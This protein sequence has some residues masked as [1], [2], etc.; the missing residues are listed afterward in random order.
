[1]KALF[2]PGVRS[3]GALLTL[4][5]LVLLLALPVAVW[6]DLRNLSETSLRRQA[7]DLNSVITGIRGYYASH[8]VG[9]V[10]ASPGSTKVLPNYEE[11]PGAIPIPATLSLELGRVISEQQAN[12][13]YRFVSDFPFRNRT[14]HALDEF[15]TRAMTSLR[16]L[17]NQEPTEVSWSLFTDRVRHVAPIVMG[18]TCVAC[19]NTHPDSPSATGKSATCA[20]SRRSAWPSRSRPTSWRSSTS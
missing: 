20:A 6:L 7:S 5:V 19:H 14:P 9:R 18:T 1:M 12:I 15:E 10:L 13:S 8:I 4:L 11:V 16:Q 3:R 2:S 17:P